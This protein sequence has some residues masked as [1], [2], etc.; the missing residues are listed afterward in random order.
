MNVILVCLSMYSE[1]S[2]VIKYLLKH[3]K[4]LSG[5]LI[6]SFSIK[7]YSLAPIFN[8][9]SGFIVIYPSVTVVMLQAII[10]KW[11]LHPFRLFLLTVCC[12]QC[13]KYCVLEWVQSTHL[14]PLSYRVV[15]CVLHIFVRINQHY[16]ISSHSFRSFALCVQQTSFHS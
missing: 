11:N 2:T 9:C 8:N 10:V 1:K 13:V 14:L 4:N 5:I 12:T 7:S 6:F 15:Y 16:F 3:V